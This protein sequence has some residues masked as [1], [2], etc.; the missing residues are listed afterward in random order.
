[1]H[2]HSVTDCNSTDGSRRR[3]AGTYGKLISAAFVRV[4]PLAVASDC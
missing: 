4:T 3:K 1:M 2:S